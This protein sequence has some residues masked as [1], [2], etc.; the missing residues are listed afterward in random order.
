MLE[1]SKLTLYGEAMEGPMILVSESS[2]MVKVSHTVSFVQPSESP[3]MMPGLAESSSW[4]QPTH[5]NMRI[6]FVIIYW[7]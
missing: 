1:G 7:G 4:I 5:R 3:Q 6:I 2:G